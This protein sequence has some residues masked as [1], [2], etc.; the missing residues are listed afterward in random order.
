MSVRLFTR[1]IFK[2]FILLTIIGLVYLFWPV[3]QIEKL[4]NT[5]SAAERNEYIESII[6]PQKNQV[7][8]VGNQ[9]FKAEFDPNQESERKI[10]DRKKINSALKKLKM[11][12]L[13]DEEDE[14]EVLDTKNKIPV[15]SESLLKKPFKPLSK[16]LTAYRGNAEA[17]SQLNY[18]KD[19]T[20]K[21]IEY[22][23]DIDKRQL[24]V[25][26]PILLDDDLI[27]V[28]RWLLNSRYRNVL[29]SVDP[30]AK[31]GTFL[32][33]MSHWFKKSGSSVWLPDEQ[34][35]MVVSTIMYAPNE[36]SEPLVSFIRLQLFDS[37]WKE[38]KNRRIRYTGLTDEQ[39]DST[40]RD[41][42]KDPQEAHFERISL[43]FPSI[44]QIDFGGKPSKGTLGPQ[45]P[46]ILYKDG[47]Y[48]SEPVIFFNM[49][50]QNNVKN[51][52][53]VFPL[54]A[55]EGPELLHPILK[56]K[57]TGTHPLSKY[58]KYKNWV[59]FFDSIKIGDSKTNDGFVY[60]AY[61]LDPLAIFKCSLDSGKCSK[62]Q[63]NNDESKFA[64]K[65]EERSV[66]LSG[67]TSFVPVP[68]QIIQTLNEKDH[69][70]LQ[71]WIAFPK[72]IIKNNACG[73]IIYRPTFT[74]LVKEDGIFRLDLL[75]GPI[76]LGL[77]T[78]EQ[79]STINE[80]ESSVITAHGI[81][82]WDIAAAGEQDA[83]SST[84][85]YTDNLGLIVGEGNSRIEMIMIKN[86]MNYLMGVYIQGKSMYGHYDMEGGQNVYRR[87]QK[88]NECGLEAALRWGSTLGSTD[89]NLVDKTTEEWN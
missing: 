62:A 22:I 73:N 40:L 15:V 4:S 7:L 39:I 55:P 52:F 88:V 29:K 44:L 67:G 9:H 8:D 14:E 86:I 81:S 11:K 25:S 21:E 43:R 2:Y 70:R 48:K 16:K 78:F 32:S 47:E 24:E 64:V 23:P 35:H 57:T 17:S 59:P 80:A 58:T 1:R 54:R 49:L 33:D 45:N 60:L 65:E 61:S 31:E 77:N 76:D 74:V 83:S 6:N 30:K 19:L 18:Y 82:F 27:E 51:M 3:H 89:N 79:C 75:T 87:T 69:K 68:R 71:M 66:F 56:L 46:R 85:L 36:R 12:P 38:I 50:D 41:Y 42:A 53:A 13:G 10:L 63:V 34:A 37:E 26:E 5:L 72:V 20:C 84:K 28:R